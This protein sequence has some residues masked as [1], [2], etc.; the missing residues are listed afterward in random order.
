MQA[1]VDDGFQMQHQESKEQQQ[2]QQKGLA[3]KQETHFSTNTWPV[4][5]DGASANTRNPELTI[6]ESNASCDILRLLSVWSDRAA[7]NKYSCH[8]YWRSREHTTPSHHNSKHAG[9]LDL[10]SL[11]RSARRGGIQSTSPSYP[12]DRIR[13]R[14]GRSEKEAVQTLSG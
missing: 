1:V 4:L 6:L 12:T 7:C 2:E 10:P 13:F 14:D 11:I 3:T 8:F 9:N 5:R